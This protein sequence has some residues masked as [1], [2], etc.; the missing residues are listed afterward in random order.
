MTRLF[1][2]SY[3]EFYIQSRIYCNQNT[4]E[5]IFIKIKNPPY[6]YFNNLSTALNGN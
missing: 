6:N 5:F 4:I 3:T 1:F 2:N